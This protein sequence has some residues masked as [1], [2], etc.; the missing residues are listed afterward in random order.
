MEFSLDIE[1]GY[2]GYHPKQEVY[3]REAVFEK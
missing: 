2:E 1:Q 3:L